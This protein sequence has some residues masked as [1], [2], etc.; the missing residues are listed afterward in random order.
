MTAHHRWLWPIV[1]EGVLQGSC[2]VTRAIGRLVKNI[3]DKPKYWREKV[4]VTDERMVVSQLMRGAGC[5]LKSTPMGRAVKKDRKPHPD[6]CRVILTNNRLPN[7]GCPSPYVNDANYTFSLYCQ[8]FINSPIF[9]TY[10]FCLFYVFASPYFLQ[11]CT[12]SSIMLLIHELDAS[13]PI[14]TWKARLS[15]VSIWTPHE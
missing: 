14:R 12:H 5:S 1:N 4:V 15:V 6:T 9:S 3:G 7:H 8:K 10:V 2:T 11:W 13:V